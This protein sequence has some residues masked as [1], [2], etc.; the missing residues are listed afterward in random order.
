M[1]TSLD[2]W[3]RWDELIKE[4]GFIAF[5]RKGEGE[6]FR[7]AVD[8]FKAL[9]ADIKVVDKTVTAVSSTELRAD[10]KGKKN[11]IPEKVYRYIAEKGLYNE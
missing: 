11:L 2:T 1:I 8:R 10:I 5:N 9:G 3:H 4:V 6:A 7:F